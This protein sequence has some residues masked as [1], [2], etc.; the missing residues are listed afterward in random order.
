MLK[1]FSMRRFFWV[2]TIQSNLVNSKSSGLEVLFRIISSSNY[3]EID[4]KIY[5]PQKL[6]LSFFFLFQAYVLGAYKKCL[7]ETY[8]PKTYVIIGSY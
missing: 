6:L 5:N 1:K 4:I 8:A 2:P 7:K 3:R